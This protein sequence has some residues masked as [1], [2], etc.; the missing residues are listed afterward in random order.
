M[1]INLINLAT[2]SMNEMFICCSAVERIIAIIGLIWENGKMPIL[3]KYDQFQGLHWETGSLRNS[4]AFQGVTAP[5][6][7]KPYSEAMLLGISGGIV[8]GY[9]TFDYQG[10]DPMV[11]ILTRNTFNP[12]QKI[13]DR[14]DIKVNIRQTTNPDKGVKNLIEVLESGLPA[15]V[16][17]DM[18][19]LPYNSLPFD[20]GMWAMLPVLVY[21]YDER[22]DMVSIADRAR[23]PLT[24]T[25]DELAA[26]R[27]R[28]KKNK[29]RLF[30]PEAANPNNL[31]SAVESGIRD[32]IQ[33]FTQSPPKGSKNNFGILAFKKWADMLQK[34]NQHG[35]W[36]RQFPPGG[37]MY[38]ALTSAFQNI[39]IFGKDG[40]AER[41]V[42]AQFLDEA[43][44]LLAN[45][46]LVDVAQKFRASANAWNKLAESL[47]P[48]DVPQFK[49]TRELMLTKHK[50]FLDMGNS[51]LVEI[52][53]KNGR[54]KEISGQVNE[55]FPLSDAQAAD[56]RES[57]RDNVMA[58]RDIEF[59]AIQEMQTAIG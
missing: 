6:T 18:F 23:V 37:K 32:C 53:Q 28:T 40:G 14:L 52:H 57:I 41:D 5:H 30:T 25:V 20:E 42:Y 4:L 47:L 17:A 55:D 16:Y 54:L 43:S 36:D 7:G 11:Q 19:S 12:L 31:K 39:T 44:I 22:R 27:G 33:L 26:A 2:N 21:G 29:S 56:L 38:A 8:M 59:E 24:V 51:A 45:T 10:Y 3:S 49:E 46:K 15:I 50:L 34:T 35:S 1:D 13:Y 48:D 9:F 58:V